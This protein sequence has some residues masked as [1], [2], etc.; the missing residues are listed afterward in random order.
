MATVHRSDER[1][2]IWVDT[3]G[4]VDDALALLYLVATGQRLVGVST[5]HGVVDARQAAANA[6]GVLA[7][8]EVTVPVHVGRTPPAPRDAGARHGSD[9]VGGAAIARA[10]LVGDG[11]AVDALLAA[12]REHRRLTFLATGPASNLA[13]AV[14]ADAT[15]VARLGQVV[16]V[17]GATPPVRDTNT[18]CDPPA[19]RSAV[20]ILAPAGRLTVITLDA[21]AT[22]PIAGEGLDRLAATSRYDGLAWRMAA[23]YH[24]RQSEE[25]GR[26][27]LVPH[28]ALAAVAATTPAVIADHRTCTPSVSE[29]RLRPGGPGTVRWVTRLRG[30]AALLTTALA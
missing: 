21:T 4:G 11:D 20:E 22:D 19:M 28:D 27:V 9:G 6:A 18:W 14:S 5:V 25:Q 8:A 29:E 1:P 30:A 10:D 16:V 12:T 15:V 24:R 7:R 26:P 17:A 13:A 2:P 23:T 3:D